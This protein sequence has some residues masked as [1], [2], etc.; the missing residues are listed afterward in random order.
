MARANIIIADEYNNKLDKKIYFY[1]HDDGN[2]E[3][4]IPCLLKFIQW[5]NEQTEGEARWNNAIQVSG[6]LII[7]GKKEIDETYEQFQ[8][9]S[10]RDVRRGMYWK[11]GTYQPTDG[12]HGDIVWLYLIKSGV[13]F[14]S[15]AISSSIEIEDVE[16]IPATK[17]KKSE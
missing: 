13:L 16:W 2:P 4:E 15:R 12:L 6:W 7:W 9:D 11:V 8:Q 17:F 1:R 3:E 14:Y 10:D 5:V